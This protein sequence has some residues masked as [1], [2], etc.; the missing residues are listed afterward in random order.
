MNIHRYYTDQLLYPVHD[1]STWMLF[2]RPMYMPHIANNLRCNTI[3]FL[4]PPHD[5][6]TWSLFVHPMYMVHIVNNLRCNTIHFLYPLHDKCIWML[7]PGCLHTLVSHIFHHCKLRRSRTLMIEHM[8]TVLHHRRNSVYPKNTSRDNT[9]SKFLH[10]Y[11][12]TC[13]K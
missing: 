4:Y 11:K 12:S 13:L 7:F 6:S 3:H 10:R 8:N 5:K 9:H 1:K 2:P